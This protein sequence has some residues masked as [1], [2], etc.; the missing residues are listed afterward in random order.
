MS[1]S[2]WSEKSEFDR[3]LKICSPRS[4]L[5]HTSQSS[6]SNTLGMLF[7]KLKL[8][9]SN[10]TL[11]AL[12]GIDIRNIS[13]KLKR[14]E[15]LLTTYWVP[16]N[17]GYTHI[18]A[19]EIIRKHTSAIAREM[20]AENQGPIIIADGTYIYHEKTHNYGKWHS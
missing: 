2:H 20:F 14:A 18:T 15:K 11:S 6:P 8:D 4:K 3:I 16:T 10:R 5:Y 13:K 1:S 12:F 17:L 7:M 19:E 9:I